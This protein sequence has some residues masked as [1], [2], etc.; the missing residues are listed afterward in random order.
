MGANPCRCEE[1]ANS[2]DMVYSSP[3]ADNSSTVLPKCFDE[4]SSMGTVPLNP[5][6][7]ASSYSLIVT[8]PG[9][10]VS[11]AARSDDSAFSIYNGLWHREID[12]AEMAIIV[13]SSMTWSS[14]FE[15]TVSELQ[16]LS[17]GGIALE[18]LGVKHE[19]KL[20]GPRLIW[21]DGEVWARCDSKQKLS[22]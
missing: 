17:E 3:R 21:S 7:V 15:D 19:G 20:E 6:E 2:K 22:D 11:V 10:Q 8:P 18:I 14:S 1:I 12:D 5:V 16:L 13:G 4:N 9:M